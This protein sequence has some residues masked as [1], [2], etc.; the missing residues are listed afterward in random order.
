M[1]MRP[2]LLTVLAGLAACG[3]DAGSTGFA[4]GM[5]SAANPSSTG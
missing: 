5:G 3:G 1:R 4:S 2:L